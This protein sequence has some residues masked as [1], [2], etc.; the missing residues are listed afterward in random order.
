MPARRMLTSRRSSASNKTGTA[1]S[2]LE[3]FRHRLSLVARF[4]PIDQPMDFFLFQ[5]DLHVA[6][7]HVGF[8][9]LAR[10]RGCR[11]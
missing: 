3:Q 6:L 7:R 11:R 10:R 2:P 4:E 8:V 5:H 1:V 9:F